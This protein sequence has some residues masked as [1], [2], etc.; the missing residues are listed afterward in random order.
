MTPCAALRRKAVTMSASLRRLPS[1]KNSLYHSELRGAGWDQGL[2]LYTGASIPDA[3]K[4]SLLIVR[5]LPPLSRLLLLWLCSGLA[6]LVM[7]LAVTP[8]ADGD[9]PATSAAVAVASDFESGDFEV[10]LPALRAGYS[11]PRTSS[12]GTGYARTLVV[13]PV[14][15]VLTPPERPPR[16]A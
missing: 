3:P 12:A 8:P 13:R 15:R 5:P 14:S 16:L 10:D 6:A 9:D 7:A 11:M 2:S 1:G 4:D